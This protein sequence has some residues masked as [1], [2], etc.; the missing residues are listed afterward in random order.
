MADGPRRI[1]LRRTKGWRMPTGAVKVDRSTTWGN[2]F[3]VGDP[4]VP[5]VQAACDLFRA[6]IL[7]ADYGRTCSTEQPSMIFPTIM[8]A[9]PGPVPRLDAIR[10]HLRGQDLACWCPL[11]TTCHAD[12]LLDL[13]NTDNRPET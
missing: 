5:D 4:G 12:V 9:M 1:Q 10:K 11:D 2:P 13:A 3:R 6:A 8:E 7:L